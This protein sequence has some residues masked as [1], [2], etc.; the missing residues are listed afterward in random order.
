MQTRLY[1]YVGPS[2]IRDAA[3]SLPSGAFIRSK[4]DI[5]EWLTRHSDDTEIDGTLVATFVIDRNGCLLV[6]P[7]RS[8]HVA[9]AAGGPVLSAGEMTFTAEGDVTEVSNQSTG[10]C[11]EP[12]SW[13]HVAAAL[14]SVP[15]P[16][17]G[18]FTTSIVFRLCPGC[19]ER[20]IVKDGWFKCELCGASLPE[21][22]NF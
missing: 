12:E 22:W 20:N 1:D 11:P 13:P 5:V 17:P 19:R 21:H 9:C 6:A 18:G 7:R 8:E 2:E 10:F 4:P 16:H 3:R 15:L 14:E